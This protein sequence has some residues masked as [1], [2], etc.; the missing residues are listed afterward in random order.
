MAVDVETG[1][2]Q[3]TK[4]DLSKEKPKVNL[5]QKPDQTQTAPSPE[6][7]SF[8][9]E[10]QRIMRE[11]VPKA[12]PEPKPE[13]ETK[14]EPD[15]PLVDQKKDDEPVYTGKKAEDW[16]KVNTRVK[17]LETKAKNLGEELAAKS[18][19]IETLRAEPKVDIKELDKLKA[20]RDKML[21]QIEVVSLERSERFQSHY[22]KLFSDATSLAKD[23][24]GTDKAETVEALMQLPPSKARKEQLNAILAELDNEVDKLNLNTAFVQMDRARAEKNE[25]LSQAKAKW[26]QLQEVEASERARKEEQS[27]QIR[28]Q[29][30]SEVL[31]IAPS[32]TAF[33]RIEGDEAHNAKVVEREARVRQALTGQLSKEEYLK[34]P[35]KAEEA[36]H[37]RETVV[38]A[39][40]ARLKQLEATVTDLTAADPNREQHGGPGSGDNGEYKGFIHEFNKIYKGPQ[41]K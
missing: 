9:D 20:E 15:K 2:V 23:A 16:K 30:I 22:N 37:L 5:Q 27:K 14:P 17:E 7:P 6:P 19:E 11:G 39:L 31:K 26:K 21:E 34:L 1:D 12:E 28:D 3:V 40:L 36:T 24:V 8:S 25:Q 13:L 41:R 38:P 32:Y 10:V 29:E 35:I 4:L 18:K 33:A